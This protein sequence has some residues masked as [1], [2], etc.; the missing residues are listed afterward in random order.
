MTGWTRI[1]AARMIYSLEAQKLAFIENKSW[2]APE[3]K[4][5]I[6]AMRSDRLKIPRIL[7]IYTGVR[8]YS[9]GGRHGASGA[10]A[11]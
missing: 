9:T 7:Y 2:F 10:R 3:D 4:P 5:A 8:T 6:C 11:E 1:A